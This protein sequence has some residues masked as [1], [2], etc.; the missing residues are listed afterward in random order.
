MLQEEASQRK[1]TQIFL[2]TVLPC[3][4]FKSLNIPGIGIQHIQ[5]AHKQ[6]REKATTMIQLKGILT[7]V[8]RSTVDTE[9]WGLTASSKKR[10]QKP[11]R[12]DGLTCAHVLFYV[13]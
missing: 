11:I 9:T 10:F 5:S 3:A 2:G 13:K 1:K 8:F 12:N 4:T 6:C 7:D